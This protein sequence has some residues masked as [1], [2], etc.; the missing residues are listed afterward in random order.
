MAWVVAGLCVALVIG[1]ASDL[2]KVY[3]R[4]DAANE[5]AS[6]GAF[7]TAAVASSSKLR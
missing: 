5:M 3:V 4:E 7:V 2:G 6:S 1:R